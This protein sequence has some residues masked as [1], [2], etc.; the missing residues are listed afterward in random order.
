MSKE[1]EELGE[2]LVKELVKEVKEVKEVQ[3]VINAQQKQALDILIKA[4][5]IA[6]S[7]GAFELDDAV[8][9]GN[10][11]NVLQGLIN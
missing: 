6:Q 11:K 10:A 9:I 1:G 5:K 7:K 2:E 3:S 8:I 4:I